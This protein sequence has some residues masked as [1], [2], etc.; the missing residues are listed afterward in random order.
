MKFHTN[1]EPW[2]N[3][4]EVLV[5]W[6]KAEK[7]LDYYLELLD[8]NTPS[9]VRS[10][11]HFLDVVKHKILLEDFI[12][13]FTAK[14]PQRRM[15]CFLMLVV[16]QLWRYFREGKTDIQ[17]IPLINGWVERSKRLFSQNE[18]R[19]V[20]AILRKTSSFFQTID[21]LPWS[22]RYSTPKF[23]LQRYLSYYDKETVLSYLKWNEGRIT[24]YVRTNAH[25]RSLKR[26]AWPNFYI[27][28]NPENW[29]HIFPMIRSG[30]AYIQD[31]MTRIPIEL[32]QVKPHMSVLDL[33][34]APGGKTL[35][36]LQALNETGCV[37][38]VD[39]PEHMKRLRENTK[40]FHQIHLLEKNILDLSIEDFNKQTL[41]TLYD[42]VLIDVPCS[43]TGVVRRKPD[44]L[45]RLTSKDFDYLPKLQLALLKN[46]R[47]F[48]KPE[49][50]LVYS[51]C[52]IDPEENQ[53][54]IEQFL[55]QNTDFQ[56]VK[57]HISLPWI[58]QH[59]GGGAFCLKKLAK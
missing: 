41:P 39:L 43:N 37:V 10:R 44:V 42:R 16:G 4:L 30:E 27:L 1:R 58:D 59:D 52:S 7:K 12:K 3:T 56:I 57:S 53:G 26:T 34:A 6:D 19:F 22:I 32:L 25:H 5:K 17:C 36:L 48:V 31:P 11:S 38:A 46:A 29:Q 14:P 20:N 49:G 15:K 45:Y 13:Q 9:Y 54:V 55:Q 35:Q 28:D 24:V 50:L 8:K 40:H 18:S 33:C 2:E 21:T 51:T 23:L 47:N